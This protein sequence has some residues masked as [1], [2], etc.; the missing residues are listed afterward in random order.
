MDHWHITRWPSS[1]AKNYLGP[2]SSTGH[3]LADQTNKLSG[4]SACLLSPSML[5]STQS[6]SPNPQTVTKCSVCSYKASPFSSSSSSSDG[7]FV[8]L[9]TD[10]SPCWSASCFQLLDTVYGSFCL[11]WCFTVVLNLESQPFYTLPK[12]HKSK[13]GG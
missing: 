1:P 11:V 3:T 13:S 5:S 7:C 6:P 2:R 9:L 8:S 4:G 10:I 12:K